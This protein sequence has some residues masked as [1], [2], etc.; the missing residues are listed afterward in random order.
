VADAQ[1]KKYEYEVEQKRAKQAEADEK[2]RARAREEEEDKRA[3]LAAEADD[4]RRREADQQRLAAEADEKRRREAE[5]QR[6][7]QLQREAE[8]QQKRLEEKRRVQEEQDAWKRREQQKAAE[9]EEQKRVAAE[10]DQARA[11]R[12]EEQRKAEEDERLRRKA[13]YARQREEAEE[14]RR[15]DEERR[16]EEQKA[17]AAKRQREIDERKRGEE[18]IQARRSEEQA[19]R[20]AERDEERRAA[21]EDE[22]KRIEEV[23][24]RAKAMQEEQQKRKEEQQAMLAEKEERRRAELRERE[25]ERLR[26]EAEVEREDSKRRQEAKR[27]LQE[28]AKR[29]T[30]EEERLVEENWRRQLEERER[31]AEEER[32]RKLEAKR[33]VKEEA[34]RCKA[35]RRAGEGLTGIEVLGK[36]QPEQNRP[37]ANEPAWARGRQPIMVSEDP[38]PFAVLQAG[39]WL[40][41]ASSDARKGSEDLGEPDRDLARQQSQDDSDYVDPDARKIRKPVDEPE[42]AVPIP[43]HE[44]S[45][46]ERRR[47]WKQNREQAKK[48]RNQVQQGVANPEARELMDDPTGSDYAPPPRDNRITKHQISEEDRRLVYNVQRQEAKRNRLQVREVEYSS[49]VN[50]PVEDRREPS[51][52]RETPIAKHEIS[53]EDRRRIWREQ[54]D[55]AKRNQQ[56][57]REPAAARQESPDTGQE[58]QRRLLPGSR[59]GRR[60]AADLTEADRHK[61]WRQDRDA[62]KQNRNRGQVVDDLWNGTPI[63][64]DLSPSPSPPGSAPKVISGDVETDS[65]DEPEPVK[66]PVKGKAKPA[67]SAAVLLD[68]RIINGEAE[69][70]TIQA[71]RR[72]DEDLHGLAESL[73]EALGIDAVVAS[74]DDA[75]EDG[76]K[77]PN[78]FH[79]NDRKLDFPKAMDDE[80]RAFRT[81]AMRACLEREIG[82]EKLLAL[83]QELMGLI[84]QEWLTGTPDVH[85]PTPIM[86]DLPPGVVCIAAQLMALEAHS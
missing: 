1:R 23:H 25:L 68:P 53:E 7:K 54:R 82:T 18:E 51:P 38:D 45:E 40:L 77:R 34:D 30:E 22:R 4:R 80:S 31:I 47:L 76:R 17:R 24:A 61:I 52:G 67:K 35:A 78:R 49:A 50:P 27:K 64:E 39:D 79:L 10:R 86:N 9:R 46:E 36:A 21:E 28:D 29:K 57:D 62:A 14:L 32:R 73:R 83:N 3:R 69:D 60:E 75:F 20:Q 16:A 41:R 59:N 85:M 19:R 6:Q 55:G 63:C 65:D 15:A 26:E 37:R 13:E 66:P 58:E 84:N 33:K 70:A 5:A 48:N 42:E 2:R 11:R 56:R 74:R 71:A 44:I 72:A 8:A 81:E 43:R 12:L